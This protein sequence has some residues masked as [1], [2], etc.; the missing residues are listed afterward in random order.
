M[1]PPLIKQKLQ[2]KSLSY[3]PS[4]IIVGQTGAG[5][6]T[7][8]NKLCKTNHV[9][10]AGRG[11]LTQNNF[12]NNVSVGMNAFWL[13]DTPGTD[14][15]T[16]TYKHAF[17]L[18]TALT[19]VAI[20]TIFVVMKFEHRFEKMVDIFYLQ[21]V[22]HY[23]KR[24]VV[25]VSHMDQSKNVEKDFQ[26]ICEV[27]AEQ[28]PD[29]SNV[30]FYSEESQADEVAN[31]MFSCISN[32]K[33]EQIQIS[34]E[35]FHLNFNTFEA[36]SE[37][38]RSFDE[39]KRKA[40]GKAE[41]NY[42]YIRGGMLQQEHENDKDNVLHMLMVTFKY[43]LDDLYDDFVKQH[44]AK[45]IDMNYFTFSIKMQGENV[46]LCD[47]FSNA[48]IPLMT[49]NLFD[50]QD[51]RNLIKQCPHCQLIWYKTEGCD[52]VTTCGNR[53]FETPASG[54]SFRDLF[55]YVK[56]YVH[57]KIHVQKRTVANKTPTPTRATH[58]ERSGYKG[59]NASIIWKDLPKLEDE[60]IFSLYKVKTIDE[61]KAMIKTDS[62][63]Q[64]RKCYESRI[65]TAF[66]A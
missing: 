65:D 55:N 19:Q 37:M 4:A 62:F 33:A 28:C 49:Y 47:E 57:G 40:N 20:N 1:Y 25:M 45:M 46:K 15:S 64:T 10:G 31:F 54:S 38:R 61:A 11:S 48:V 52:G 56:T 53:T 50:N 34:D 12:R 30:I 17:L 6:T 60:L 27:F 9:A 14:S 63:C 39:Y 32:M 22:H 16:D 23:G 43:E 13:I 5:K 21:P 3:K 35:D 8:A 51:P 58:G 44:G 18:R 59:C 66:H 36:T 26:E 41:A 42:A 7:L 2:S 24:I 29:V